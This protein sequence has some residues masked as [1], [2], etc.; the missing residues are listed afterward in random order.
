MKTSSALPEL[1]QELTDFE[2]GIF[3]FVLESWPVSA[4]DVAEHFGEIGKSREERKKLSTKYAYHLKKL[5][6][7]RVLISKRIGNALVVWPLQAEKL[8]TI[9]HIL[10]EDEEG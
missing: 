4:L 8:R 2:R 6:E 7:K 1:K 3:L 5:V 9:H 10:R